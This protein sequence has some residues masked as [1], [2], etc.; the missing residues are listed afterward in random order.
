MRSAEAMAE[1]LRHRVIFTL[2]V[3]TC[4]LLATTVADARLLK[5]MEKDGDASSSV[6][7][8]P[9]VDLQTIFGSAEGDAGAGGLRWLKSI[10]IDMLGGIKD[11]GPSPGAG[12]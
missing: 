10:S 8:S 4:L 1:Q 6:V 9:A 7:E 5:R 3:V 12:H 2:L 11:S